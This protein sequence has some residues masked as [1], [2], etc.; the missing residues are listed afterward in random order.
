MQA[1][2]DLVNHQLPVDG[3][4]LPEHEVQMRKAVRYL[5]RTVADGDQGRAWA[6]LRWLSVILTLDSPSEPSEGEQPP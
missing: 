1:I 3:E 6:I 4:G 2:L 5:A